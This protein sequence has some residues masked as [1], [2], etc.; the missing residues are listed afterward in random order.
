MHRNK[1]IYIIALAV[2]MLSC[3]LTKGRKSEPYPR[4]M[5]PTVYYTEGIKAGWMGDASYAASMFRRA[6]A[7]DS[8]HAPSY[9][10]LAGLYAETNPEVAIPYSA[11]ACRLDTA[12]VWYRAQTG[13]LMIV[14]R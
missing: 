3:A 12:N 8:L 2:L 1:A 4:S 5:M 9:Y 13:R 10:E 7:L 6:V 14:T 11:R